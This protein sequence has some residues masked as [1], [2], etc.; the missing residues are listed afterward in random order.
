MGT[1]SNMTGVIRTE[2][3]T[4]RED[5]C[6]SQRRKLEQFSYKP[7]NAKDSWEPPEAGRG[8]EGPSARAF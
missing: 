6:V 2:R 8:E 7:G 1:K 4:Q 5:S 3:H